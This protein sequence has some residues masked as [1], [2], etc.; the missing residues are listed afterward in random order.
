M[1]R[2]VVSTEIAFSTRQ[3]AFSTQHSA[4]SIQQSAFSTQLQH[5][6]LSTWHLAIRGRCRC[7]RETPLRADWGFCAAVSSALGT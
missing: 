7:N 6:A 5:L 3:S 2:G 4:V 1:V